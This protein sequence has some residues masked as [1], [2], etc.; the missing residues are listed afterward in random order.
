MS[1][2]LTMRKLKGSDTFKMLA[3]IGK[4]DIADLIKDIFGQEDNLSMGDFKGKKPT[5]AEMEAIAEKRGTEVMIQVV[6][7]LTTK[8][9]DIEVELNS[10]LGELTGTDHETIGDLPF[11][12]Y[13]ELVTDFFKKEELKSFFSSLTSLMK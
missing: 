8:L 10:F 2:K 5:K 11:D 7:V 3:I 4:L 6:G 1:N 9:P 12:E 13:I